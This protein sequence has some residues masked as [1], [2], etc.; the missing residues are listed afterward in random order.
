MDLHA[1][2]DVFKAAVWLSES[3]LVFSSMNAG[4]ETPGFSPGEYVFGKT[5]TAGKYKTSSTVLTTACS[6]VLDISLGSH[7]FPH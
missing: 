1:S 4:L 6:I 2:V 7:Q 3:S 5:V